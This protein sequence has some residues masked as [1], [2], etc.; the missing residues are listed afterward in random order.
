MDS[1]GFEPV[2]SDPGKTILQGR[3]TSLLMVMLVNYSTNVLF[4]LEWL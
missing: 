2:T 1:T 4:N 3:A